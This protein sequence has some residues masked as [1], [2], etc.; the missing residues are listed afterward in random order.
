M[1]KLQPKLRFPEF[2][3]DWDR[4]ILG[5]I[6][7]I[8]SAARVHKNEWAESGVTFFRSSDVVSHFKGNTNTKAYISFELY[9]TLSDKI[10]RV[11]K[12]DILITGGGSIGIPF[13]V[14]NNDP[15][16]F[17]DA[18]LLWIKNRDQFNGFFL[19]SFFLTKSFQDYLNSI[20]HVG[21]IAHYT[22]NQVKNTPFTYPTLPE[23]TK[24]ASF[25]ITV[26][27]KIAGLKKQ[28]TLLERYKKG[29]MQKIFSQELRFKEENG[30]DFPD[31]EEKKLGEIG[32]FQ[33]SS[34]DKLSSPNEEEVFLVNYMNVYRHERINNETKK[35]LQKVTAKSSQILS[36]NLLKG[37][38][39]FTPS[40]ETPS[41]IGHSVVIFEDLKQTVYSYHLMR[42]RP[43]IKIDI[44][45][46][47]Y[48]CNVPK[49]LKQI[50]QLAT[51][52][53]RFT[54]SVKAFSSI[55]IN[56]PTLSEQQKIATFLSSIDE[57][58][59]K[60]QGQIK[61]MENWKKGL[62]QQMFV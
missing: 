49:V 54:I 2:E 7:N 33:T 41:D 22:I 4:K 32:D 15:L 61:A 18:D 16:Y 39:L 60:C 45:Y 30:N 26:D 28:L 8:S 51:G 13:L 46:S 3:G 19:Y 37:D 31:W 48:F 21:T 27:E 57:K 58:I 59:E 36:C 44:L 38:I 50:S 55:I 10:G 42:Y 5:D 47:H 1:E 29:V 23:Q 14:K 12:D 11:K 34:I 6:F 53:T 35:S 20:S 25:L 52:S 24:I 9:N 17:K 62:L 43:K 40:S 56:L